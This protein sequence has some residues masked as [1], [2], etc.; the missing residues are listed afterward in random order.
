MKGGW[1]KADDGKKYWDSNLQVGSAYLAPASL[2]VE[3]R[4]LEN[5]AA[6][7]KA[8]PLPIPSPLPPNPVA[9][10]TELVA[11][12]VF[13]AP[14]HSKY[15]PS[16]YDRWSACSGSIQLRNAHPE[17]KDVTSKYAEEGSKLHTI[18]ETYLKSRVIPPGSDGAW[19]KISDYVAYVAAKIKEAGS[20]A[21]VFIEKR[22][23]LEKIWPEMFGTAD[24]IIANPE[25]KMIE[26]I[27]L[28][29][30][31]GH[32]VEVKDNSQLKIYALGALLA[33]PDFKAE[34]VKVTIVQA[35]A[36]H[37]DGPIRSEEFEA[38]D[39][40][41]FWGEVTDAA[42]RTT[43][44]NAPL[45][46]GSH[47]RWCPVSSVC[48]ELRREATTSAKAIFSA[49]GDES[50]SSGE[51][52]LADLSTCLEII[53][54]L[55]A[56]ISMTREHAFREACNGRAPKGFKLVEKRAHRKWFNEAGMPA[57]LEKEFGIQLVDAFDRKVKS[58]AQIEKMVRPELKKSLSRFTKTASSGATLVSISD[59]RP[60]V[61]HVRPEDAFE[62]F[63]EITE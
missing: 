9:D 39:L 1:V 14:A 4:I 51:R 47:C 41:D 15:S 42:E 53:P 59:P 30:G 56:W 22:L 5:I 58:P 27:D 50:F 38:F 17:I 18:A 11:P 48:P 54:R 36:F 13:Q 32:V 26:V 21:T 61:L 63:T 28:K 43:V 23:S 3:K 2:D 49:E 55:E 40:F 35:S 31:A 12:S 24:A 7:K 8:G 44:P 19:E 37:P 34:K 25:T 52:S 6:V 10:K 20:D 46:S 60:E 57:I 45:T 62:V 33:L 29:T 16:G